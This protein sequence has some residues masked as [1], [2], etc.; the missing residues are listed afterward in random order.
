M[1]LH[2]A[3]SQANNLYAALKIYLDLC[4]PLKQSGGMTV[5]NLI[6]TLGVK[7]MAEALGLSSETVRQRQYRGNLPATWYG[8]IS[9]LALEKGADCPRDLFGFIKGKAA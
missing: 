1:L 6:D 4:L 8:P 7:D 9:Q 3:T 5:K 2:R